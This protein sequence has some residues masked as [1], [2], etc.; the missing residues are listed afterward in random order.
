[1]HTL[2]SLILKLGVS[3]HPGGGP[4]RILSASKSASPGL[5][6]IPCSANLQ[7]IVNAVRNYGRAYYIAVASGL[8]I[9]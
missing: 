8:T 7:S 6:E 9:L 4:F 2:D 1:M 3:Y 5:M